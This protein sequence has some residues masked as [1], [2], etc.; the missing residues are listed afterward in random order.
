MNIRSSAQT[1]NRPE[2]REATS[3]IQATRIPLPAWIRYLLLGFAIVAALGPNGM[4]LYT[5]FTDP[6]ANQTAMQNPVALVFMIEAMMLLALFLGYVY[7]RTRSWLQVLLYLALAFAGSLAFS[8]P[9]FMFVQSEPR[10]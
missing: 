6:S 7:F 3:N 1:E 9:L 2:Q 8:F 4:Y 10:E 5:L